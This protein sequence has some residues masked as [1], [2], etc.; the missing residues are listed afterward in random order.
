MRINVMTI[1][2]VITVFSKKGPLVLFLID[3]YILISLQIRPVFCTQVS[4]V[5]ES[6]M[7]LE[8]E[9]LKDAPIIWALKLC[10]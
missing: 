1:K 4:C 7:N 10:G 6:Q 3:N 9:E 8:L 2:R 5:P